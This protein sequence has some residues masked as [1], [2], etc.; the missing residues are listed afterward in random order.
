MLRII[1]LIV[2]CLP[3]LASAMTLRISTLYPEGTSV[4][5]ALRAAS[6]EIEKQ[7]EGRVSL[8]IFPG[9]VMGDDRAVQRKISIGQLH[10]ALAQGGAFSRF[11]RDSQ[12]LNLPI[13]FRSYDEVDYV[14]K[15]LDPVIRKGFRDNGWVVF[16]PVDGGFAYVMSQN[17]VDSVDALRQQKLW[18][19]ANDSGSEKAAR[20]FGVSPIMLSVGT[21]LTSLQTGAIDAF[22]APPVAALTLQWHSRVKHMSEVP[23]L[24]TYGMLGISNKYFSSLTP[25]DQKVVE[26][27][28]GDAFAKMDQDSREENLQAYEAIQESLNMVAPNDEQLA[29]W[30]SYADKATT[31]LVKDGEISKAIL[32]QLNG[33][34]TEFRSG[35]SS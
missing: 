12:I 4:V 29:E 27:I 34:L 5:S 17:K 26:Q 21:V 20:V 22:A 30:R 8:R 25:A 13:A 28:L 10:G 1:C 14:R 2:L 15:T 32:D 16:G 31:Q 9:G 23:L 35:S 33:L 24:Y 11:Y 6:D 18:L 3:A 19:P 7:T